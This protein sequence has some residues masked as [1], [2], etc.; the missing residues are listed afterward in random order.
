MR[1]YLLIYLLLHGLCLA[2]QGNNISYS[3]WKFSQDNGST[4]Q[5]TVSKNNGS[6][7]LQVDVLIPDNYDTS[8][9]YG[10]LSSML[11]A[12][13]IFWDGKYLGGSG[14]IGSSKETETPG[15]LAEIHV[16]PTRWL[17]PG[18]HTLTVNYSN[19]YGDDNMRIYAV[20][21]VDNNRTLEGLI[22][23]TAYIH[24]YAGFFLIIGLF[25]LVRFILDKS[26]FTSGLFSTLCLLFFALIIVEY[27]KN[28]WN[29]IYPFHFTR[30]KVILVVTV[31]ISLILPYF[32]M[33][34]F[35]LQHKWKWLIIPYGLIILCASTLRGY[36]YDTATF[37]VMCIGFI[38]ACITCLDAFRL[39][40][41]DSFL[42]MTTIVPI[43]FFLLFN[44]RYYDFIL[45]IGF[46][47]LV[48]I[49]LISLAIRERKTVKEKE[50]SL[51]LSSR[52][53]LD[54]LKKNIQPHF[55]NNSLMSAIDWIE[56]EPKK[57]VEFLFAISRELD[58]MIDISEK[59]L[60]PVVKELELCQSHLSIMS[61][62]KEMDFQLIT[63]GLD[64]YAI[65]PP[66]IILTI[67]EN[68]LSH[69]KHTGGSLIF[70]LS[71]SGDATRYKYIVHVN[72][73][74]RE[75][76]KKDSSGTGFKYIQAR[77]TESFGDRWA[78]SSQQVEDGWE[79]V[80]T[81]PK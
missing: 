6:Y 74:S 47:L 40:K 53:K 26:H 14:K 78:F 62:R 70:T 46:G 31:L 9:V 36:G 69:Q 50:A 27:V 45:Y 21:V 61:F 12:R 76:I 3:N 15:R 4:F 43:T 30:L 5:D 81:F 77:L 18:T 35:G 41:E 79:T 52:L 57:G 22:I 16:L 32:F 66:A 59:K 7:I 49:N 33:V 56:R 44:N 17:T 8:V 51:L 2:G 37:I 80:F 23:T 54:L 42:L 20:V 67:I 64:E 28:Y 48:L 75:V 38:T 10:V 39:K 60:I 72:G 24:I 55:L 29:Y 65:I 63:D 58:I 11:A 68:G 19:Y 13:E 71:E 1:L 73:T 34:R 25:Y